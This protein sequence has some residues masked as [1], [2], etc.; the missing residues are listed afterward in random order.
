MNTLQQL[1]S[2]TEAIPLTIAWYLSDL[3]EAPG[4]Q[5]LFTRQSPLSEA[6]ILRLH[7]MS[8]RAGDAGKY[9]DKENSLV[10]AK[11]RERDG[12]FIPADRNKGINLERGY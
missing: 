6:A 11:D 2:R 4:K 1:L 12:F 7:R 10:R 3:S 9:K 5:E 8:H